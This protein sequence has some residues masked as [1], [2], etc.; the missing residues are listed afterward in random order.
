MWFHPV[1]FSDVTFNQDATMGS[2]VKCTQTCLVKRS[3]A[4]RAGW[5][6]DGIRTGDCLGIPDLNPGFLGM[7][8]KTIAL[9]TYGYTSKLRNSFCILSFCLITCITNF[10]NKLQKNGFGIISECS[11]FLHLTY[12]FYGSHGV[13]WNHNINTASFVFTTRRPCET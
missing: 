8:N 5:L 1:P 12:F 2:S 9:W 10:S 4:F 13:F 11:L 6:E 7:I 3:P